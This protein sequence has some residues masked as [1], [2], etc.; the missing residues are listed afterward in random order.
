M[1][2]SG[3]E[4]V[5][6]R[7]YDPNTKG[8]DFVGLLE[9]VQSATSGGVFLIHACA[10]NPTGLSVSNLFFF[11][12]FKIF[13]IGCDPTPEQWGQLSQVMLSK[14]HI[15]FFDCAYQGFASGD[16]EAD[17]YAIRKFV[18]DGHQILLAQSFAKVI[19]NNTLQCGKFYFW[20]DRIL[21]CTVSV[22][23]PCL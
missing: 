7:Y 14:G 20:H 2:S 16:S 18:K 9:D 6:Y 11:P 15:V 22:L 19:T 17:A 13:L 3:L 12:H 21:V 23:V 10:H 4:P 5:Y 8:V 1:K